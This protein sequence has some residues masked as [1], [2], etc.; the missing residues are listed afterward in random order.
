MRDAGN[1]PQVRHSDFNQ[2][3]LFHVRF[4]NFCSGLVSSSSAEF[5]HF[6]HD[7]TEEFSYLTLNSGLDISLEELQVI[8]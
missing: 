6:D 8:T 3:R 7:S 4:S 5:V 2:W 1:L